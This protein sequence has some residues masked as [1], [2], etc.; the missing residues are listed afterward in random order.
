MTMKRLIAASVIALTAAMIPVTH[1]AGA[2]TGL[3]L[4]EASCAE[5]ACSYWAP[6]DCLCIDR[7]IPHRRPVCDDPRTGVTLP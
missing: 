3:S 5:G 6:Y 1:T 4:S 7:I 2:N